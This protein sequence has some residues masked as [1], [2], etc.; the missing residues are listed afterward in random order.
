MTL[1]RLPQW[2]AVAT[3]L[4]AVSGALL[5]APAVYGQGLIGDLQ[6]FAPPRLD[7]FGGGREASQGFFFCYDQLYWW[8]QA[9]EEAFG[10]PPQDPGDSLGLNWETSWGERFE[11]GWIGEHDG[12]LLSVFN[13]QPQEQDFTFGTFEINMINPEEGSTALFIFNDFQ[14]HYRVKTWDIELSYLRRSHQFR[15]GGYLEFLAGVRYL[16]LD[17][18][19]QSQGDGGAALGASQWQLSAQNHLLGPQ[20]GLRYFKL[21]GR[22]MLNAEG[23]FT[24]GFNFQNTHLDFRTDPASAYGYL[25]GHSSAHQNEWSPLVE[26]RLELRYLI[27][28]AINLRVGW[29]GIWMDGLARAPSLNYTFQTTPPVVGIDVTNNREDALV[30]GLTFGVDIN[31]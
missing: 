10:G 19:L 9:P 28:K 5:G 13:L 8:I 15:R 1:R 21:A 29:T 23:R 2:T 27:T 22:W 12:L 6:L 20:L 25:T 24:A 17:D 30:H 26:L 11:F 14:S 16:E 7:A 31:R 18:S 4:L 3:V